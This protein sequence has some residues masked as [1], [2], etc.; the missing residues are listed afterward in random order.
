[1]RFI[2]SPLAAFAVLAFAI[3]TLAND[4]PNILFIALDD[5]KQR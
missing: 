2:L 3:S 1:M 4:R 5:L